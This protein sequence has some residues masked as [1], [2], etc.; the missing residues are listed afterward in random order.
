[1]WYGA[2]TSSEIAQ[3]QCGEFYLH[4]GR[5]CE[6]CSDYCTGDNKNDSKCADDGPCSALTNGSKLGLMFNLALIMIV[7]ISIL[8]YD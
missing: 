1:M 4:T 8:Y 2:L 3:A 6:K 5:E 7:V